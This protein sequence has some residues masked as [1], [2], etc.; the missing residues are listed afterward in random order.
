MGLLLI[1]LTIQQALATV[2]VFKNDNNCNGYKDAIQNVIFFGPDRHL[3][4]LRLPATTIPEVGAL[5]GL[6]PDGTEFLAST[7][8]VIGSNCNTVISTAHQKYKNGKSI[9]DISFAPGGQRHKSIKESDDLYVGKRDDLRIFKIEREAMLP[10][11]CN[12]NFRIATS[13]TVERLKRLTE[14]FEVNLAFFT[15]VCPKDESQLPDGT[16][17]GGAKKTAQKRVQTCQAQNPNFKGAYGYGKNLFLLKCQDGTNGS[18]GVVSIY[19]P[20][21]RL[22]YMIGVFTASVSINRND[23]DSYNP[24][25]RTVNA[26]EAVPLTQD[27]IDVM[28]QYEPE[29]VGRPNLTQ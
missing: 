14:P 29:T 5:F 17:P 26:N 10:E 8:L 2:P 15:T 25:E 21:T 6:K 23:W 11:V 24:Y 1:I 19:D 9:G 27:F 3:D 18:G 12:R 7:A 13:D 22:Y 4:W 16:C 28:S 20:S